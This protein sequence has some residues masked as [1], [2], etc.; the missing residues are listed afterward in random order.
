MNLWN[1]ASL[2]L[3]VV[4]ALGASTA[5]AQ[6]TP[7][8]KPAGSEQSTS[9]STTSTV[10]VAPATERPGVVRTDVTMATGIVEAVDPD[11]RT[12]TLKGPRGVVVLKVGPE[13]KNLDQVKV[14]DKVKAKYLES[15]ALFV[16]KSD[17]PPD[18]TQVQAVQ[19]APKGQ[20]PMAAA[21]DVVEVTAHVEKIDYQKRLITLRGPE[22]NV[23]TL[24]VD[25][26]VKRLNEVK[27]GDDLVLR[28]TQAIAIGIAPTPKS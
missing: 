28:M 15:V 13:V 27:V 6:T 17:A 3:A 19:V 11:K 18:A 2:T 24:K 7:T 5:M 14:G 4:L 12:V 26:R 21:V 10:T 1:T 16:R 8:D 20:K 25:D 9:K 22:G 23:R